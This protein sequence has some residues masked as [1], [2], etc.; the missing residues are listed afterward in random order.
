MKSSEMSEAWR[1]INEMDRILEIRD[2]ILSGKHTIYLMVAGRST[3][4]NAS[5]GLD[6]INLRIEQITKD[7]KKMG[8]EY[9]K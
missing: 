7:M 6:A 9:G 4:V 2:N 8:L 3:E 1:L 5:F